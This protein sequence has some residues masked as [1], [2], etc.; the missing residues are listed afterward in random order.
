MINVINKLEGVC[1]Q[2]EEERDCDWSLSH[3][4]DLWMMS[5][6]DQAAV[7]LS[8]DSQFTSAGGGGGGGSSSFCMRRRSP[9]VSK[10]N[11]TAAAVLAAK[12]PPSV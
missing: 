4:C 7:H 2:P 9:P 12:I 5:G 11:P 3:E 8:T 6:G 10:L 1:Y